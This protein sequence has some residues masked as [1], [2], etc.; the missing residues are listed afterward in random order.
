MNNRSY[1]N[2]ISQSND[3]NNPQQFSASFLAAIERKD[4]A[5]A[6]ALLIQAPN[7]FN[8]NHLHGRE[9]GR[10]TFLMMAAERGLL[11]LVK[12]L[13]AN[14]A[15]ITTR[16]SNYPS[17]LH[18]AA[19]A[20]QLAVVEYLLSRKKINVNL[21]TG[22]GLTPLHSAIKSGS[23]EVVTLL[24]NHGANLFPTVYVKTLTPLALAES[25]GNQSI[26]KFLNKK[27]VEI[28]ETNTSGGEKRK[29]P[30]QTSLEQD[31]RSDEPPSKKMRMN[32]LQQ[33]KNT[34]TSSVGS[35]NQI[36]SLSQPST[37]PISC[38]NTLSTPPIISQIPFM[39]A[40]MFNPSN[41]I[42]SS[43]GYTHFINESPISSTHPLMPFS[44]EIIKK[45]ELLLGTQEKP[46]SNI[47]LSFYSSESGY[48]PSLFS[49]SENNVVTTE[50]SRSL[51]N[52]DKSTLDKSITQFNE[53][54][55]MQLIKILRGRNNCSHNCIAL[56]LDV[57][58][59]FIT[60]KILTKPSSTKKNSPHDFNVL[61]ERDI[62][63]A[64]STNEP[65]AEIT[66]S[67][68]CALGD[69]F[70]PLTPG[71]PMTPCTPQTPGTPH[72]PGQEIP[73]SD[74]SIVQ[75]KKKSN[76][77]HK[78]YRQRNALYDELNDEL[79]KRATEEPN[80]VSFG[81]VNLGRSLKVN[82]QLSELEQLDALLQ[83]P[84]HMLCYFATPNAV[85]YIDCQLYNGRTQK[86]DARCG[87]IYSH[88]SDAHTFSNTA[89]S[90]NNDTFGDTVFYIPIHPQLALKVASIPETVLVPSC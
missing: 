86:N 21:S 24:V 10:K 45:D 16:Y 4:E 3:A 18:C 31:T 77:T 69:G 23:I 1:S 84:G 8:I 19:E 47:P 59:Y 38:N 41:M 52:P 27:I 73:Q 79:K 89:T 72:T 32:I 54:E 53:N 43:I 28:K 12:A 25:M 30:E 6:I 37:L 39:P 50:D 26:V 82:D 88:L 60:G 44:Q 42:V 75:H 87:P 68:I 65:Y 35:T 58:K 22:N 56:S 80:H 64:E 5:A 2:Q 78:I 55:V 57:M 49:I 20:G 74:L 46:A 76:E 40:R 13:I 71:A 48:N 63:I 90:D 67:T 17:V 61:L 11:D 7:G 36:N 34:T 9:Y 51:L 14:K 66:K 15:R 62:L 70:P 81:F 83:M 33:E 85:W 29:L